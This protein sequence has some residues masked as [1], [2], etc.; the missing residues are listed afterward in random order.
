MKDKP[1]N[2]NKQG[3]DLYKTNYGSFCNE[4]F[5][6]FGTDYQ[7]PVLRRQNSNMPPMFYPPP[8]P[9]ITTDKI[10]FERR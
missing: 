4:C 9:R 8:P 3:H 10:T 1:H 6:E 7:L 5:K 2:C